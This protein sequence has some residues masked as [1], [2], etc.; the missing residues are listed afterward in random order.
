[1]ILAAIVGA[2]AGTIVISELLG[3]RRVVYT[4]FLGLFA[5]YVACCAAAAAIVLRQG[6]GLIDAAAIVVS[7]VPPMAAWLGF[8]IHLTNSITLEM[9][10]LMEDGRTWTVG[11]L[12]RAYDVEG[13]A[14]TRVEIL[15]A[16]GYLSAD[17][18]SR[19]IDSPRSRAVLL[20][21]RVVCGPE[22]P[23]MVAES[24]R[25]RDARG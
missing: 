13:H 22:G 6:G 1:M 8:R 14:A 18:D 25:R 12:E 11:D 20:L 9:A 3:R 17:E 2:T 23:R 10:G 15:R 16:G 5:A 19:L 24:L 4:R 21:M 7:V